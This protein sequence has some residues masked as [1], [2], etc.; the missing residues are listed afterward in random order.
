MTWGPSADSQ[1]LLPKCPQGT[2]GRWPCRWGMRA[3]LWGP[4]HSTQHTCW[5][6]PSG[7]RQADNQRYLNSNRNPYGHFWGNG[8]GWSHSWLTAKRFMILAHLLL[9]V[10][11]LRVP[12]SLPAPPIWIPCRQSP[13]HLAVS[14]CFNR[15]RWA[16]TSRKRPPA[17]AGSRGCECSYPPHA[18]RFGGL[19]WFSSKWS[20]SVVPLR[21]D[22]GRCAEQTLVNMI[23]WLGCHCNNS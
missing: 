19:I 8:K 18:E 2:A 17:H 23:I 3:T 9:S 14:T 4:L 12:S 22:Q 20:E 16:R 6:F 10:P 5:P 13:T 7:T 11:P 1:V 15:T 21:I